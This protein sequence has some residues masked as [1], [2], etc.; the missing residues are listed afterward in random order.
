M[1][2]SSS[3]PCTFLLCWPSVWRRLCQSKLQ[4]RA[5]Y[6]EE[7]LAEEELVVVMCREMSQGS[8][9]STAC[10]EASA[11]LWKVGSSAKNR[12]CWYKASPVY[13]WDDMSSGTCWFSADVGWVL[14]SDMPL[15]QGCWP[16]VYT[17]LLCNFYFA[18]KA[19]INLGPVQLLGLE[20]IFKTSAATGLLP[21]PF[22]HA[23]AQSKGEMHGHVNFQL[24]SCS[25]RPAEMCP[26]VLGQTCFTASAKAAWSLLCGWRMHVGTSIRSSSWAV[27][28][29]PSVPVT[30]SS[31][32]RL[33]GAVI[34]TLGSIGGVHLSYF[35]TCSPCICFFRQ[36]LKHLELKKYFSSTHKISLL[37]FDWVIEASKQPYNDMK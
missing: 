2:S 22:F 16:M 9:V 30:R 34:C 31:N 17:E 12:R 4:K 24:T 18:W 26:C 3:C 11:S 21:C 8:S 36:V 20:A 15:V 7:H 28:P 33:V 35:H 5:T 10:W 1:G 13:L 19:M 6:F 32:L 23:E 27:N 29:Q 14:Q 25:P 37:C